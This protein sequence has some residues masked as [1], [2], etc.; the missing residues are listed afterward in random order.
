MAAPGVDLAGQR[1]ATRKSLNTP[2]ADGAVRQARSSARL[3]PAEVPQ[4]LPL[5]QRAARH[6][7][8]PILG[9]D[10]TGT[11]EAGSFHWPISS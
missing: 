5:R 7:P 9:S 11:N 1:R 6:Q 3:D 10:Y 4:L 2:N 8:R